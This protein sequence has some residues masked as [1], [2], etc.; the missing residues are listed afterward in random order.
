MS[1]IEFFKRSGI[2]ALV[3]G[4][5][6]LVWM[7]FDVVLVAVG[8]ILIAILLHLISEPFTRWCRLPRG[9]ALTMSVVNHFEVH[10]IRLVEAVI[11]LIVGRWLSIEVLQIISPARFATDEQ[12]LEAVDRLAAEFGFKSAT[13]VVRRHTKSRV[14][15][16]AC[17][18]I[19]LELALR[20]RKSWHQKG[21]G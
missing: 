21:V 16:P 18:W 11:P 20:T 7:L 1:T 12:M 2:V 10:T 19:R 13:A 6:I 4:L 17:T 14:A 15:D 3:V 9:L 8:A 5:P